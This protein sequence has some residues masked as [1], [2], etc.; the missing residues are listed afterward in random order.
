M[1]VL[2]VLI[3]VALAFD[4]MN[5]F[6]D[7]ANSIATVGSTRVLTPRAAVAWAAFFN[8]VAAFGF[9]VAVATTVGKGIVAPEVVDRAVIFAALVAAF[10]WDLI[11]W[12]YGLPSSS[13]HALIAGLAGAGVAKAGFGVLLPAGLAEVGECIVVRPLGGSFL[14][15]RCLLLI[16]RPFC[17]SRPGRL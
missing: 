10:L 16:L 7:A 6:H 14:G 3:V 8:F 17:R 15:V 13:S 5:G 2:V 1:L 9:G 12:R 11:T 4:F